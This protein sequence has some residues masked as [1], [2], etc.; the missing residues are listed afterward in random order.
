MTQEQ[1]LLDQTIVIRDVFE[2]LIVLLLLGVV[3]LPIHELLNDRLT[4]LIVG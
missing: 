3:P 1:V 4:L 2:Q